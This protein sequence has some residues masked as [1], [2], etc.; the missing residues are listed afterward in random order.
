MNLPRTTFLSWKVKKG[1]Q[2]FIFIPACIS[3]D[4]FAFCFYDAL[5]INLLHNITY[6]V[7]MNCK[8]PL[9]RKTNR[10]S[11]EFL[12]L[13][14]FVNSFRYGFFMSW[15]SYLPIW[16]CLSVLIVAQKNLKLYEYLIIECRV[17]THT[18][19]K[20]KIGR[21]GL[22]ANVYMLVI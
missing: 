13:D 16:L 11:Y 1:D 3:Y 14:S 17:E 15:K 9:K 12:R 8:N 22:D 18:K 19:K 7:L 6:T 10:Q 5:W 20:K 4:L 2:E 21:S